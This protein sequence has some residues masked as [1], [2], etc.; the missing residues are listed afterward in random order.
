MQCFL[1]LKITNRTFG[2]IMFV[3]GPT[4]STLD[5]TNCALNLII[6][7][8]NFV[9]S[10]ESYLPNSH[11]T[12]CVNVQ[13]CDLGTHICC[14]VQFACNKRT[15]WDVCTIHFGIKASPIA[16]IKWLVCQIL[17]ETSQYVK[18]GLF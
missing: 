16:I 17:D 1:H 13:S 7:T 4:A 5:F 9:L 11:N 12:T 18:M 6:S 2:F 15:L 8:L 10:Y 3:L 14:Q